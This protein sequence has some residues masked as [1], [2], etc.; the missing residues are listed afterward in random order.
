MLGKR[1]ASSSS[2][3]SPR[4]MRTIDAR[5]VP[6]MAM[7]VVEQQAADQKNDSM[8]A[9]FNDSFHAAGLAWAPVP[10]ALCDMMRARKPRT[11]HH[12][13]PSE[14]DGYLTSASSETS[15]P[16]KPAPPPPR[17]LSE[18]AE[19]AVTA[20][21]VVPSTSAVQKNTEHAVAMRKPSKP[22][23][24]PP[25]NDDLVSLPPDADRKQ[26]HNLTERRRIDRM[27]QLFERLHSA[28]AND[29]EDTRDHGSSFEQ[30]IDPDA[31]TAAD[32]KLPKICKAQVLEGALRIIHD[33][34]RQLAQERLASALQ[35]V[36]PDKLHV[37]REPSLGVQLSYTLSYTDV[38]GDAFA[39]DF[40]GME[41][42]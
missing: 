20:V 34:R 26:R 23:H 25:S 14:A 29:G 6:V 7:K 8:N 12:Q 38:L 28:V 17:L 33:L 41:L 15:P 22:K 10:D 19:A 36:S 31:F 42:R 40:T 5:R 32:D 4:L 18:E 9:P 16:V 37:E 21:A 3:E 2:D 39:D 11:R 24:P 27:N 13:T 35:Q 1:T 30:N